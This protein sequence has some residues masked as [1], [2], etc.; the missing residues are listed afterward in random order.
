LVLAEDI[1]SNGLIRPDGSRVPM[2]SAVLREIFSGPEY[3]GQV[4][5]VKTEY[6]VFRTGRGDYVVFSKSNRSMTSFHMTFVPESR[7]DALRQSIPKDG[8]TSGAMAANKKVAEAFGTESKEGLYFEVLTTLYVLSAMN[9]VQITKSG[10]NLIFTP[11]KD[12]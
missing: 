10:R 3:I 12:A 4:A 1:S 9:I 11:R 5:G 2:S 6:H 7:V 8:T